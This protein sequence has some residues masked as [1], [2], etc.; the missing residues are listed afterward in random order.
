MPIKHRLFLAGA[1]NLCGWVAT[2]EA[3]A[4]ANQPS[5]L[6]VIA[7]HNQSCMFYRDY[8]ILNLSIANGQNT[9]TLRTDLGQR[10]SRAMT[11]LWDGSRWRTE[12]GQAQQ[13]P[14][15]PTRTIMQ[16]LGDQCRLQALAR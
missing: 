16:N 2:P 12:L 11:L 9:A 1:L 3:L 4:Q 14:L 7:R 8:E 6:L 13:S 5:W 10:G 15:L